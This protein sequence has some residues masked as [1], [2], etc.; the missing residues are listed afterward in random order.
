M[1]EDDA[2]LSGAEITNPEAATDQQTQEPIVSMQFT[3]TG[4]KA[5][6]AATKREA[7]RGANQLLPP[8]TP[9]EQA[10]QRFAI[11]LDNK[12]VSLA[13][14]DFAENPEGIDGRTGA[15]I[16]GIGSIQDTAGPRREP[17]HRRAADRAE[18][19]LPDPDL[20]QPRRAGARPGP[21]GGPGGPAAHARSS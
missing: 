19:D 11:T 2:E 9:R 12:I 18:A 15:Q 13:T 6:A 5:F 3:D 14:I 17:A 4:R 1:L 20:G 21:E 10:F 8:G 7:Q 16:N